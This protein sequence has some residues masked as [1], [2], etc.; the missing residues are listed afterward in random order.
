[1]LKQASVADLRSGAVTRRDGHVVIVMRHY[2][3]GVARELRDEYV[4]ALA[5]DEV[6]FREFKARQRALGDHDRA[7]AEVSY[8]QRF[9]L[10]D[11]G[12]RELGRLCELS[13]TRDVYLVCQC[14]VGEFCHRELLLLTARAR[15]AAETGPVHRHYPQFERRLRGVKS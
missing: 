10:H 14:R 7:F 4:R 12:L 5:P 11:V 2:P 8:E 1:M 15:H 3:R 13:R 6:L 9:R